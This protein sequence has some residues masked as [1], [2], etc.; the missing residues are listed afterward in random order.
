MIKFPEISVVM[1]VF[2]GEK[3]LKAAIDSVLNQT[4]KDFEFIIIND[5][6]TDNSLKIIE[7]YND[8]R[9]VLLNQ[10]NTGLSIALNNGIKISKGRYI[11]R[12]DADDLCHNKRLEK[13]IAFLNSNTEYILIGSNAKVIDMKG[14]YVYSSNVP[15]TWN[16]IVNRFPESSFYHSSVMYTRAAFIGSGG[17]MEATSKLYSFEDSILWNKMKKIGMMANLKEELIYYR[18]TPDASTTKS[19]K[20]NKLINEILYEIINEGSLSGRNKERLIELKKSSTKNEKLYSYHIHLAKKYL[21]NNFE[22]KKAI[23]NIT[24]AIITN[25]FYLNTYFFLILSFFP[26]AIIYYIYK[27]KK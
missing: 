26:K 11:A 20:D 22:R 24:K 15:L 7:S 25:P 5:G 18:L 3:Y 21:W 12:M 23:H 27:L 1:S 19:S 9:I 14:E 17:Y 10:S 13:Q 8:E 2:N 16:E 6:S 4:F